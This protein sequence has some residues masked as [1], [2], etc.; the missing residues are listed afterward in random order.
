MVHTIITTIT[1]TKMVTVVV[2]AVT[3]ITTMTMIT[4]MDTAVAVAAVINTIM[5]T[6]TVMAAVV[7]AVT[8]LNLE[9]KLETKKVR[10]KMICTPKV[11]LNKPT[12]EVQIFLWVN[13]TQSNLNYRFFN[14]F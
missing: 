9:I 11:G 6:D 8:N 2:A 1:M 13:T 5:I 4:I 10:L 14:L 3:V 7:A 12:I